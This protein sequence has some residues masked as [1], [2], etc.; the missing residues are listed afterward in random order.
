MKPST[1]L[2]TLSTKLSMKRNVGS[3]TP[4]PPV[5]TAFDKWL[6]SEI[7]EL[8]LNPLS[9]DQCT[10]AKWLAKA[11]DLAISSQKM[12]LRSISNIR[13]SSNLGSVDAKI[14]DDH[15]DDLVQ[16]LDACNGLK[17]RIEVINRYIDS[18]YIA[19]H[20]IEET[21]KPSATAIMR[22]QTLL[23]QCESIERRCYE[24]EK[25]GSNLRKIGEKISRQCSSKLEESINSCNNNM[26]EL[27][28]AVIGSRALAVFVV[29]ILGVAFSFKSK[30]GIPSIHLQKNG[31]NWESSFH[32]VNREVK[33]EFDTRRKCS[34]NVMIELDATSS[35]ARKLRDVIAKKDPAELKSTAQ[36]LRRRCMELEERVRPFEMKVTELFREIV[37]VRMRLLE[38]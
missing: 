25:C 29:S 32:E 5:R 15:L 30:R 34:V 28:E 2:R 6:E 36:M 21:H 16:L 8:R 9:T 23:G 10:S 18:I 35:A 7:D 38:I 22:A 26:A 33:E 12:M 27:N 1:L 3:V 11:L 31:S 13:S 24:L 19:L 4:W 17:Q 20:W 14:V 37:G